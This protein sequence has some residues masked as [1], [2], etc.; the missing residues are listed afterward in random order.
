MTGTMLNS[1]GVGDIGGDLTGDLA[2]AGASPIP[3]RAN[4]DGRAGD[5]P[6]TPT[7]V[8]AD[9]A[10]ARSCPAPRGAA[11]AALSAAPSTPM[12]VLRPAGVLWLSGLLR[13]CEA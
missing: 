13:P 5:A 4:W 1:G 12:G 3:P 2:T 6:P 10:P 11:R 9:R 8:N 7:P